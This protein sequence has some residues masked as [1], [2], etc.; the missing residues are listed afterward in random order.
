VEIFPLILGITGPIG[1]GKS[2]VSALF[3]EA[4]WRTADA[5]GISLIRFNTIVARDADKNTGY[6]ILLDFTNLVLAEGETK[7][8]G[9]LYSNSSSALIA[10]Y[11]TFQDDLITVIKANDAD[12]YN[13]YAS[14]KTLYID[15][16][17][18]VIPEPATCAAIFGALAIAF[19]LMRRRVR[20]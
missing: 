9:I 3:R 14:G 16:T 2:T 13:I 17:S 19:A 10:N 12:T 18:A 20:K 7:T 8:M 15:Y 4:G 5:D 1:C 11:E 6:D